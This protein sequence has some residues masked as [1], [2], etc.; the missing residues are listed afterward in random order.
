HLQ[1]APRGKLRLLFE[2]N[3]MAFLMEQAG[4]AASDGRTP[5]LDLVPTKLE[6][7]APVFIGCREDVALAEKF[8]AEEG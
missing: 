5:I 6:E 4:G 7:R 3:P 8:I 1:N 2:L